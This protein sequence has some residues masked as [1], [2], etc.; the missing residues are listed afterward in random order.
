MSRQGLRFILYSFIGFVVLLV[1]LVPRGPTDD[2]MVIRFGP[3]GEGELAFAP[4]QS[5]SSP[6]PSLANSVFEENFAKRDYGL[7]LFY[8]YRFRL[9][10]TKLPSF[11]LPNSFSFLAKM[12]GTI[13]AIK[14]GQFEG[15]VA[16][17][18]VSLGKTY[19]LAVASRDFRWWLV[20]LVIALV[21][22]A[23]YL[24]VRRKQVLS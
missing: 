24:M 20:I 8:E 10:L 3:R 18:N 5:D 17:F 4:K 15:N 19:D 6:L 1:L 2:S 23:I 11:S 14:G 7:V 13:T 9:D 12:P 16:S 22:F 21:L